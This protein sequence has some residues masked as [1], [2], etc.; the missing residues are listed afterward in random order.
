MALSDQTNALQVAALATSA[1]EAAANLTV[2]TAALALATLQGQL[3]AAQSAVTQSK[4]DYQDKTAKNVQA[5]TA[6]M[7]SAAN[8]MGIPLPLTISAPVVPN[9]TA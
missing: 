1:D 3:V 5:F 2:T 7:V 8:D 9:V 6:W 4:A